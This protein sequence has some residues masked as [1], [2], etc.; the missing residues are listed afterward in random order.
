MA[1]RKTWIWIIVG[2]LALCVV[3]MLAIAGAG[4]YFVASHIDTRAASS[5]DAGVEF[6]KARALLSNQK[7]LFELDQRERPRLTRELASLP[8]AAAKPEYLWILAFDPDRDGRLVRIN[9]PFWLLRL[10]RRKIQVMDRGEFDL[11]RLN[12]DVA[13]LERIGPQLLVDHRSNSG[14]R[15]L[16]WTK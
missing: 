16:V 15:V 1:T 12:I 9:L 6:D 8:T 5:S 4:V 10:G 2:V 3:A 13:D 7:P 11:S 14:E